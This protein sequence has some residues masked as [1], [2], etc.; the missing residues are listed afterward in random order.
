MKIFLMKSESYQILHRQQHNWNV[1]RSR[2]VVNTS[3]KKSMRL[4]F[5]ALR[6]SFFFLLKENK[7]NNVLNHS[8]P[9]SYVFRHFGEY[10]RMH[11]A[12]CDV[13]SV[14]YIQGESAC[15]NVIC[16]SLFSLRRKCAYALWYSLKWRKT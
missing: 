11:T 8:S 3:V 9:P 16:V 2:N 6:E 14:A 5:A 7:N 13:L 12:Y 4:S 15:M 10:L 1:P